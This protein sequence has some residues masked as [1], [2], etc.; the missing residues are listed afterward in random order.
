MIAELSL[1]MAPGADQSCSSAPGETKLAQIREL[2]RSDEDFIVAPM[3]NL[4]ILV[5]IGRKEWKM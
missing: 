1:M 4:L 3:R 5:V 2:L